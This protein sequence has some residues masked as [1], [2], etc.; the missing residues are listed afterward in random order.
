MKTLTIEGFKVITN[1]DEQS[2]FRN[3][4]SMEHI[5]PD[6]DECLDNIECELSYGVI[7]FVEQVGINEMPISSYFY[8][9]CRGYKD[10]R[11]EPFNWR[12]SKKKLTLIYTGSQG[13][14]EWFAEIYL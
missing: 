7:D 13:G 5:D 1:L 3:L 9:N 8:E 14:G 2:T 6:T 12:A 4:C 10:R 11:L